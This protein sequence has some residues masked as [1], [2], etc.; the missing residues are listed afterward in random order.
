MTRQ[1]VRINVGILALKL[2]NSK[3]E[4][5]NECLLVRIVE[6]AFGEGGE[7]WIGDRC[8][9]IVRRVQFQLRDAVK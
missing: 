2:V 9:G 6:E 4:V 5:S 1:K 8:T 3:A 7:W